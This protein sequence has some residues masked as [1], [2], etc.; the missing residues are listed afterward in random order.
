MVTVLKKTLV[1]RFMF[2]ALITLFSYAFVYNAYVSDDAKEK[3]TKAESHYKSAQ[4][5]DAIKLLTELSSDE[6]I[7]DEI[8]KEA[9]RFLGRSYTAKGLYDDAKTAILKLLELEPPMV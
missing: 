2:A 4:F 8:Q 9:L 3:L 6:S 1:N 5:D 7:D